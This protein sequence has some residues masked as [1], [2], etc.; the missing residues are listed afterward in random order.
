MPARGKLRLPDLDF[1]WTAEIVDTLSDPRTTN[2]SYEANDVINAQ[3]DDD[4]IAFVPTKNGL[5]AI[6]AAGGVV[7]LTADGWRLTEVR[8]V[9]VRSGDLPLRHATETGFINVKGRLSSG[10]RGPNPQLFNAAAGDWAVADDGVYTKAGGSWPRILRVNTQLHGI[11]QNPKGTW[12]VGARGVVWRLGNPPF[13]VTAPTDETLH[14]IAFAENGH[15]YAV[16]KSGVVVKSTN[17]GGTWT[18]LTR[19]AAAPLP[20]GLPLPA[21]WYLLVNLLITVPAVVIAT[22]ARPNE[23]AAEEQSIADRLVSDRALEAGDPDAMNLRSIAHGISRFLRND[24]TVPPLTVAITGEWGSGKSSLMNLLKADLREFG[25]RPVWFNAWHHQKEQHFLASLVQAIRTEA[26]PPWW[27]VPFRAR[28]LWLRGKRHPLLVAVLALVAGFIAQRVAVASQGDL[29]RGDTLA[30]YLVAVTDW[31]GAEFA[32]LVGIVSAGAA[33][34]KGFNTFAAKPAAL[35]ASMSG[36]PKLG[37]LDAEISFRGRFAPEFRDVTRALGQRPLV[38]FID[39]LDRCQPESVREMLE[40][41]N[42]LVTSGDCFVVLGI[43]RTRVER[44]LNLAFGA[45]AEG[46]PNFAANYL[47]KLI[48]IEVPVPAPNDRQALS[49]LAPAAATVAPRWKPRLLQPGFAAVGIIAFGVMLGTMM[50]RG[51]PVA[52]NAPIVAAAVTAGRAQTPQ[53]GAPGEPGRNGDD[54]EGV[55]TWPPGDAIPGEV[56]PHWL[57]NWPM[58][59]FFVVLILVAAALRNRKPGLIVHDSE[60][61]VAALEAWQPLIFAKHRTPRSLKRF[62]N[63]VRYLAMRQRPQADETVPDE[64]PESALVAMAA[65]A[66][67]PDGPALQTS[68]VN[69]VAKF[70]RF[71]PQ[72]WKEPFERIAGAVRAN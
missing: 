9:N 11:F 4:I 51:E 42:F 13:P 26:A 10:M 12:A 38:I 41:I 23:D 25:F 61:F 24:K 54:I 72:E 49:I 50:R 7:A 29:L 28:L 1:E 14:A 37:D 46:E 69:H 2:A 56:R 6:S 15:G 66:Q 62:I 31:L 70:G 8:H 35:L 64:M 34:W 48:N 17:E 21:P 65:M 33:L 67:A 71:E 18:R 53:N 68:V 47:D 16:G 63:R 19:P 32:A 57:P 39:D 60:E 44:Y 30:D 43:D 55:R 52:G 20:T 40:A 3:L 45:A 27:H 36:Q 58:P 5:Q 22:V 59:L